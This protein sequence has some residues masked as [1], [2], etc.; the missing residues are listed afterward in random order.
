M[1]PADAMKSLVTFVFCAILT[2]PVVAQNNRVERSNPEPR[3]RLD[4][5]LNVT[6]A[7]GQEKSAPPANSTVTMD[8]YVVKGAPMRSNAPLVEIPQGAP[9]RTGSRFLDALQSGTLLQHSGKKITTEVFAHG[10][11]APGGF[12]RM[13]LGYRLCW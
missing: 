3:V 7:P 13:A 5:S 8:R 4:P 9:A 2:Y 6:A 11:G 10:E 12:A 1:M